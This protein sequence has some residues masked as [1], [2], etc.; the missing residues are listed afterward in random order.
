MATENKNLKPVAPPKPRS[1]ARK[2]SLARRVFNSIGREELLETLSVAQDERAGRLLELLL[3]PEYRN[4]TFGRLCERARLSATEVVDLFRKYKIDLGIVAM[5]KRAPEVMRDVAIDAQSKQSYCRRCD[6][7]GEVF[8]EDEERTCP[9]C[10]GTG[11]VRTRGDEKARKLFFETF[12][13][14]GKKAPAVAIQQNFG[15]KEDSL[16]HL[17]TLAEEAIQVTPS[18]AEDGQSES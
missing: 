2:D 18:S 4:H 12:R 10:K 14:T 7:T 8:D 5:A 17:I 16:E 6:G 1:P 3:D 15:R 11:E 9:A 13:L